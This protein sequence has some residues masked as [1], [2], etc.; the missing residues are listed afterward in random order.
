MAETLDS[1]LDARQLPP[2]PLILVSDT[3]V[4]SAQGLIK[5]FL[6]R[7]V[8]RSVG[9]TVSRRFLTRDRQAQTVLIATLHQ[10]EALLPP[11]STA[12]ERTKVVDLT[13]RIPGYSN[14]AESGG[15]AIQ[16]DIL[17]ACACTPHP[18]S[19]SDLPG[20]ALPAGSLV[21]VDS[22]DLLAEDHSSRFAL[23]LIR[24]ILKSL[25]TSKGELLNQLTPSVPS[26]A[27]GSR[28]ILSLPSASSFLPALLSPTLSPALTHL[29]PLSPAVCTHLSRSYLARIDPSPVFWQILENAKRRRVPEDLAYRGTDGVELDGAW[30][31]PSA[32]A[33]GSS[34][35][36]SGSGSGAG[37]QR[38][39]GGAVV[40]VLVRKATGGTKGMTRSLAALAPAP[41]TPAGLPAPG[42]EVREVGELVRVDPLSDP[43]F[44]RAPSTGHTPGGAG[45]GAHG[46]LDLPFNLSLTEEQK[47]RRGEVELPYVHEGE[48]GADVDVGMEWEDEDEDDEEV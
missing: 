7:S 37:R 3:P 18:A 39:R 30:D 46:G 40:Q 27:P 42:L 26:D 24:S 15:E 45:G 21:V 19:S 1:V 4:F 6:R 25:H 5:E 10:P 23:N 16:R 13:D 32:V 22:V 41:S 8:A 36:A 12:A 38:A 47:R 28:L 33:S 2:S 11:A 17:G 48:G 31:A 35:G 44:V 14:P 34:S 20:Q 43:N 29:H 9:G